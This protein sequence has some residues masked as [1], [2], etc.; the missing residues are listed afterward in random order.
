MNAASNNIRKTFLTLSFLNILPTALIFGVNTLFLLDAGLSNFQAFAANAFFTAGLLLFEIPTGM[1]ADIWG[2]R[3]S[4]LLGTIVQCIGSLMYWYLWSKHAG[5]VWWALASVFLGLGWTFFSGAI[6]AWLVDALAHTK[7][8][9]DLEPILARA[10]VYTGVG[11][12]SGAV[13]GGLIAQFSSLGVPYIA[14]SIFLVLGFLFAF[15]RMHDLGFE[16]KSGEKVTRNVL[17]LG[18]ASIQYGFKLPAVRWMILAEM[19]PAG[20]LIYAFYA[21]QPYLLQLYGNSEAI[22]IAGLA[23]AI[24]AGAQILGGFSSGK[25]RRMFSL[26]TKVVMFG[27]SVSATSLLI[28]GL[29]QNFW[30]AIVCL[31]LWALVFAAVRPTR[32]AYING[33]IP[34]EQRATVLS[35]DS[36][37]GS[38]GGVVTQPILGRVADVSGYAASYVVSAAFQAAAVPFVWLAKKQ[39]ASSDSFNSSSK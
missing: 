12:L 17:N 34:S 18:Q 36:L 1:V 21:M 23:A 24:V 9:G 38:V 8:K 6:E 3:T 19:L 5:F 32:Q 26:R 4:Y 16:R 37:I 35:F 29:W 22:W 2:R 11:M 25:I 27:V 13:I 14:R 7:H 20:V 33:L 15:A 10:Q 30:V 39:R 28:M 31:V